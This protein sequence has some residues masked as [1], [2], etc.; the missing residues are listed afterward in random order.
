MRTLSCRQ[1][2]SPTECLVC[3]PSALIVGQLRKARLPL[4]SCTFNAL[5]MR[6]QCCYCYSAL[7]IPSPCQEGTYLPA[8]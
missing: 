3:P 7:L 4:R 5:N 1:Q 6:P 8:R 2:G